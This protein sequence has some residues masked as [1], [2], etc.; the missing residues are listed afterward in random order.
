MTR[1]VIRLFSTDL[2]GTILGDPPSTWRF[3][4]SWESLNRGVRPLLVYNT[5]RSVD[6]T[7]ALIESRR[8]PA[9]EY[10]VGRL[11]TELHSSLYDNSTEFLTQF[12]TGWDLNAINEVVARTPRVRRQ[13]TEFQHRYKSSWFWDQASRQEI[14]DLQQ[15]LRAAGVAAQAVYSCKHF[16]DIVPA[17]AGK[18]A[19]L[20]WLC[21]RLHIPLEQVLVAGDTANDADMFSFPGV[22]GIVV[23][24]ALPE[25]MSGLQRQQLYYARADMGDGVLEGLLHF[26]VIATLPPPSTLPSL[27]EDVRSD[28]VPPNGETSL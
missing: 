10:I 27:S 8:L 20:A 1:S 16:L 12:A 2:D 15:R 25:L 24:N 23:G 9:P 21:E 5:S 17:R 22:N 26:G 18:G 7:R 11:G 19:A 4:Q 6:D 13:N 14:D 28:N 3:T